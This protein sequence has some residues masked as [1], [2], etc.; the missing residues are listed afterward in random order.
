[1]K[2]NKSVE[3]VEE[4]IQNVTIK[5]TL[6]VFAVM[7]V[8]MNDIHRSVIF[9]IMSFISY[10]RFYCISDL[11]NVVLNKIK[12]AL[13]QCILNYSLT[14]LVTGIF[15]IMS[16]AN[17][18]KICFIYGIIGTMISTIV[19]ILYGILEGL[20]INKDKFIKRR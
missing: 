10:I 3:S 14:C 2:K 8:L 1:M 5:I 12:G 19:I 13:K 6:L 7:C 18:G 16:W 15:L 9:V 4:F 17:Y 11:I 20:G